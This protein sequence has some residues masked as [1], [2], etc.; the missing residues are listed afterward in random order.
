MLI[1]AF[2][3]CE[4]SDNAT[5]ESTMD[6]NLPEVKAEVEAAFAR[7]EAALMAN[8]VDALQSMFWNSPHT[9]RYGIGEILYGWEQIGAFR[10]VRS[11]I[12]LARVIS[13]TVI[14]TFGRDFATASTL[15][16][17]DTMPGRV[18]RQQQ[19]WARFDDGWHIVAAHV[20]VISET[21]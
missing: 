20:S 10:S 11:P 21:A 2:P 13:R 6:V 15:F 7:Y 12:G 1:L 19:T 9:I 17:R 14:T 16:H 8:D 4:H 5:E 3:S 18:G